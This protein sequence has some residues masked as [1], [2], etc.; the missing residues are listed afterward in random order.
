MTIE[1]FAQRHTASVRP[2]EHVVDDWVAEKRCQDQAHASVFAASVAADLFTGEALLDSLP[3][4]ARQGFVE[5]MGDKA[6]S[7][8]EIKRMFAEKDSLGA[9]SLQG[10]KNKIQGQIG[11][12]LFRS[13]AGSGAHL[14]ESGSQRAWDVAIP[15]GAVTRYFQVKIYD[16]A[17][18]IIETMR[19]VAN[20]IRE[21]LVKDGKTPVTSVDFAVNDDVFDEVKE[22]VAELGLTVNVVKVGATQDEVRH[23][24]N[25]AHENLVAAPVE[26]FFAQ[27]LGGVAVTTALHAA[28]NGFLLW[29]GAKERAQAVEDTVYESVISTGGVLAGQLLEAAVLLGELDTAAAVLALPG[30]GIFTIGLSMYVR[31][32]L[33]R[34]A[35]RRHCAARLE[36]GN[37]SLRVLSGSLESAVALPNRPLERTGY[38]GRSTPVR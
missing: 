18:K 7:L 25:E 38:A 20:D 14:A 36:Q 2:I 3:E 33:R 17:G 13:G 19:Q 6:N 30:G 32:M 26:N 4:S 35:D 10:L 24:L 21:G 31:G 16:D 23:Y 28:I 27:L 9:A 22:R 5:L 1:E 12:N 15:D 29:K 37:A 11:E 34:F 8:L